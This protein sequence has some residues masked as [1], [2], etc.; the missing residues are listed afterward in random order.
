MG[1]KDT[2]NDLGTGGKVVAVLA[3]AALA[4]LVLIVLLVVLVVLAA[5]IGTFTLGMGESVESTP[6]A[7]FSVTTADGVVTV[8]HDGGDPIDDDS[9]V[10]QIDDRTVEWSEPDGTVSVGD[11]VTIEDAPSGELRVIYDTG[12]QS[13]V[14]ESVDLSG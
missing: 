8:T 2:W 11:E 5:V 14:L 13:F 9:L 1:L 3:A 12:E 4:V 6:T 10:V 7:T